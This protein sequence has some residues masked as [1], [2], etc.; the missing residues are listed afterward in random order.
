MTHEQKMFSTGMG[1]LA[2]MN[3]QLDMLLRLAQFTCQFVSGFRKHNLP[4]VAVADR[5]TD[6]SFHLVNLT[7]QGG[8]H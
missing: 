6:N 1:Y 5:E 7:A 2:A 4:A 8:L 3:S